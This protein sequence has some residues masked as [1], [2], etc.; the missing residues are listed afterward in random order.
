MKKG[1]MEVKQITGTGEGNW[2]IIFVIQG[3]LGIGKYDGGL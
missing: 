3:V 1:L 2:W